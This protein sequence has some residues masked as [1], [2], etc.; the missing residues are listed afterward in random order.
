VKEE[1][2]NSPSPPVR[3]IIERPRLLKQLEETSARTI[4]L[5]APAGYG[6]TTLARQWLQRKRG[7]ALALDPAESDVA[8][9]GRS[10]ARRLAEQAP[11]LSRCVDEAIRVAPT[12]ERQARSVARAILAEVETPLDFW[13]VIDEYHI[14]EPESP[15]E[16][17]I[18][19][20][21]DSGRFRLLIASRTRPT[22]ATARRR[23]YGEILELAQ[24][25]LALDESEAAELLLGRDDTEYL[26]REARGWPALVALVAIADAPGSPPTSTAIETLY[27]FLAEEIFSRISKEAQESLLRL[28]LLPPLT[29]VSLRIA[30]GNGAAVDEALATGVA[31][32]SAGVI[33]LHPLARDFLLGKITGRPNGASMVTESITFVLSQSY[34]NEAFELIKRF[35]RLEYLDELITK[36]YLTLAEAGRVSTLATFATFAASRGGLSQALLDLTNSELAY[37]EGAFER[38]HALGVAAAT[39]L[40]DDH[41][42]KARCFLIAGLGA[43]LDWRMEEAFLLFND[44][45]AVSQRPR[46]A[47]DAS[48]GRCLTAVF[49]EDDRLREVIEEMGMQEDQTAE[50]RLRLL[51]GRQSVGRLFDGLYDVGRDMAVAAVLLPQISDPMVR[52]G[53]GNTYGYT[54]LLQGRYEEASTVL[55]NALVDIEKYTLEFGRP[56]IEW[57]LAASKL[58][59]RQFARA[60]ALL[61]RVERHSVTNNS[62]YLQLNARALRARLLL[63]QRRFAE[64]VKVT[65]LDFPDAPRDAMYGEYIATRALALALSQRHDDAVAVASDATSCTRAVEARVI[66]A[67]A[68][69]VAMCGTKNAEVAAHELLSTASSL[70]TWDGLVCAMRAS[71]ALA[72]QLARSNARAQLLE[73]LRRSND[74]ALAHSSGFTDRRP[75]GRRGLL[76]RREAEVL[77]LLRQGLK[78]KAIARALYIADSTV[79]VHIR[80]ILDKLDARTRAEA[81]ARYDDATASDGD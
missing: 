47:N 22:W 35:D 1:E 56:H 34:W 29:G 5:I 67:A 45:L 50:D 7:A 11:E 18:R 71:P 19:T 43:Q 64:A 30:I 41:S 31:C 39:R 55:T 52:T 12:P 68:R 36:S 15:A 8:V 58:G 51:M 4:L 81:V 25:E 6:K 9:L 75:R 17:L 53:W 26:N 14:L 23:L 73:V 54:L 48:W 16:I 24:Q 80:N 49:L 38:A 62:T 2:P 37:R 59:L 44:A 32:E 33:D 57:S 63:S 72:S 10:I 65:T 42:L 21:E 40:P 69:A 77:D 3:R 78:T 76:S 74:A 61:R 27:D 28:A 70:D 79:K 46:D 60:D 13:L 66:A 20:L